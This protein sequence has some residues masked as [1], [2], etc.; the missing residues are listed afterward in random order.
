MW[1]RKRRRQKKIREKWSDRHEENF[2]SGKDGQMP[3]D[4]NEKI[5]PTKYKVIREEGKLDLLKKY[6]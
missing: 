1:H 4:I 3:S 2:D 6:Y 5:N